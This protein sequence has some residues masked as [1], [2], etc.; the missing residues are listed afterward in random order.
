MV[1]EAER[2]ITEADEVVRIREQGGDHT[3]NKY[4]AGRED[5]LERL[6]LKCTGCHMH[7][8][9]RDN[10]SWSDHEKPEIS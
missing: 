9:F 7:D 5:F 3:K 1:N 8:K 10:S 2:R 6:S 4:P